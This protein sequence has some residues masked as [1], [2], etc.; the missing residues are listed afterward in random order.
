MARVKSRRRLQ[1]DFAGDA[2]TSASC[3]FSFVSHGFANPRRSIFKFSDFG[4][5]TSQV[6]QHNVAPVER[7][8]VSPD[9]VIWI[10]SEALPVKAKTAP[11]KNI[12]IAL[13]Q[14]HL[15]LPPCDPLT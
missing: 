2:M 15:S 1:C 9:A 12:P 5:S 6:C 8:A 7:K 13:K 11:R 4:I 14:G 10:A 3:H